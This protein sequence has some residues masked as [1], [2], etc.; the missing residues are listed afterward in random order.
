MLQKKTN[1]DQNYS[2]YQ[3]Y[4]TIDRLGKE[5]LKNYLEMFSLLSQKDVILLEL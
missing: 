4:K 3:Q 5:K 2:E 1:H